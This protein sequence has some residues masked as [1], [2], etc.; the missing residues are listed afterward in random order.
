MLVDATGVADSTVAVLLK[1]GDAE[2]IGW[3]DATAE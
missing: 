1:E 3:L 2:A